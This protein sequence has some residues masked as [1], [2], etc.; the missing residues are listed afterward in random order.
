MFIYR[1]HIYY[2]LLRPAVAWLIATRLR[3]H[4]AINSNAQA[5]RC[6]S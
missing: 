1:M 6:C 2:K 3:R 4:A 5:L